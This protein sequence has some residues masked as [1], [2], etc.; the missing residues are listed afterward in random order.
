MNEKIAIGCD[1]AAFN[2]KEKLKLYLV[3]KG[4]NL[5]DVGTN[6]LDSVD[7]PSYGHK[8]GLLVSNNT[9]LLYTSPSP[10]D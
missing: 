4:Y 6:S 2:E 10:R 8:V 9:C 5:V 7:Y 1:H 3:D